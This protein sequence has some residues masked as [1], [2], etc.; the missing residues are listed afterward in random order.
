MPS[1]SV[2]RA[3]R[4]R[5]AQNAA[6]TVAAA[7]IALVLVSVALT[8]LAWALISFWRWVL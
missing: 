3:H 7:A 8:P 6:A 5:S 1:S 4:R 2:A